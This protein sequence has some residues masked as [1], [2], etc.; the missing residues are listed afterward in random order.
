MACQFFAPSFSGRIEFSAPLFESSASGTVR[1]RSSGTCWPRGN[2]PVAKIGFRRCRQ[3]VFV[4]RA[5]SCRNSGKLCFARSFCRFQQTGENTWPA[6][7]SETADL[8]HADSAP[9]SVRCFHRIEERPS[10]MRQASQ[11]GHLP[12]G[13]IPPSRSPVR[14]QDPSVIGLS[15]HQIR[16]LRRFVRLV[17]EPDWTGLASVGPKGRLAQSPGPLR[18]SQVDRR[19]IELNVSAARTSRWSWRTSGS[20]RSSSWRMSE[21]WQLRGRS[22]PTRSSC[23]SILW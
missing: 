23:C 10:Q 7:Q 9:L 13:P 11:M 19:R 2:A 22:T 17:V 16:S 8:S 3:R 15:Q 21:T 1:H 4:R 20:I 18:I 12:G 5:T 14:L 6:G